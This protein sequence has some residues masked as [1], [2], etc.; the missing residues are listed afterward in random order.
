[1]KLSRI[2]SIRSTALLALATSAVHQHLAVLSRTTVG[3]ASISTPP[4]SVALLVEARTCSAAF[5]A[6]AAELHPRI[7]STVSDAALSVLPGRLL[8]MVRFAEQLALV[9]L[10]AHSVI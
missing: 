7:P 3:P 4:L 9:E 5:V 2:R 1:C 8:P 6:L 10:R